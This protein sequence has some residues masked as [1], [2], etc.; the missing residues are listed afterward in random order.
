[1]NIVLIVD[2]EGQTIIVPTLPQQ[3]FGAPVIPPP[4]PRPEMPFTPTVPV[5]PPFDE[6]GFV[7][8]RPH[9]MGPGVLVIP[10]TMPSYPPHGPSPE[11]YS[12]M[13]TSPEGFVPPRTAPSPMYLVPPP[14]GPPIAVVPPSVPVHPSAS[15]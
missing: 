13:R 8:P 12:D 5:V 3:P 6:T 11:R 2:T 10:T 7:P 14:P 1:M 9:E 4:M 15:R